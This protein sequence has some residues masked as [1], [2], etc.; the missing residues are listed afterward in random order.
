MAKVV[1]PSSLKHDLF[2][3]EET[4]TLAGQPSLVASPYFI[5][6]L[7]GNEAPWENP[8]FYLK[9]VQDTYQF[10]QP[11]IEMKFKEK[12]KEIEQMMK[13]VIA[14]F[15]MS[16]FW[17]NHEPVVLN[18]WKEKVAAFEV[19]PLNAEERLSFVLARPFSY[20]AYRQMDALMTEQ[21]KQ[22]AKHSLL[23]NHKK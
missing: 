12:D 20:Q 21:Q 1:V 18:D 6:E 5:Y 22:F 11:V 17:S 10:I 7:Q 14:L 9:T 16:L 4:V 3:Q 23:S 13:A 19:K 15:F 8:S 2:F